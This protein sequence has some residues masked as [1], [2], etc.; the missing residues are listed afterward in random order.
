MSNKDLV[1]LLLAQLRDRKKQLK[2]MQAEVKSLQAALRAQL[3]PGE[4]IEGDG[5]A[6]H[7]RITPKTN[8]ENNQAF[9]HLVEELDLHPMALGDWA[10]V[11][12][13]EAIREHVDKGY[14]NQSSIDEIFDTTQTMAVR[15]K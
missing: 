6:V 14:I 13:H 10:Y 3:K 9:F 12:N 4:I 1:G 7:W 8:R 11:P 2:E 5:V 15:V